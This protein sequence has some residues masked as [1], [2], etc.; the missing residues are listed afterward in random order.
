MTLRPKRSNSKVSPCKFCGAKGTL[1]NQ[2]GIDGVPEWEVY[3]T[4]KDGCIV[5]D[6][7]PFG[8]QDGVSWHSFSDW[9]NFYS[10]IAP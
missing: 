3:V 7:E 5:K 6:K 10:G 9:T 2:G 4:H 8:I 1:S